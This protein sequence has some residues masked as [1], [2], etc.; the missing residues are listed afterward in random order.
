MPA[1]P[2]PPDLS[3]DDS[4]PRAVLA[5]KDAFFWSLT[6]EAAPFGNE[7][8]QETLTA[9]RDFRDERPTE[10]PLSLLAELLARWEV[11]DAHWDATEP[12]EVQGIGEEDEYGLLTRD[13]VLLALAFSQLITE[14]RLHPE[15]RR[16]ALLAL[17][18]QS[19]PALLHAWGAR[20][21]ERAERIERMSAVLAARWD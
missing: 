19:L 17:R 21:S 4:H 12:A 8:A 10:S 5:L 14:G 1:D 9:F 13:E 3:P 11:K 7:A 16:R 18:R 20:A 15:L 6:D 2:E